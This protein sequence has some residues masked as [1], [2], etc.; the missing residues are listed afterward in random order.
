VAMRCHR[1][2]EAAQHW[3]SGPPNQ[4]P[5]VVRLVYAAMADSSQRTAALAAL[6]R[7]DFIQGNSV[8]DS[9][10]HFPIQLWYTSLG[11]L[12]LAYEA[13]NRFLD[14]HSHSGEIGLPNG[15]GGL[16]IAQMLPFRLDP[17]FQA[18]VTRLGLMDYWKQFG[19][20]DGYELTS[21]QLRP[22]T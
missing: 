20:P 15:W 19:P 2:A 7:L 1:Y 9:F 17:R 8:S 12:D 16:W 22:C 18:L 5:A 6:Q 11:A 21:G 3:L 10:R 14:R 4:D 13:A